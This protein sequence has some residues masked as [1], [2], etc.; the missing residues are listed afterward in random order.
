MHSTVGTWQAALSGFAG[1]LSGIHRRRECHAPAPAMETIV[2]NS[3]K[4]KTLQTELGWRW[5]FHRRRVLTGKQL[6]HQ[7]CYGT[8]TWRYNI[9]QL[10]LTRFGSDFPLRNLSFNSFTSLSDLRNTDT[11]TTR[12]I[13]HRTPR[14][15]ITLL[16]HSNYFTV[17]KNAKRFL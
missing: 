10:K 8:T 17:C 1:N 15:V 5:Y 11:S 14:P 2:L 16:Q 13:R 3:P 9:T 7:R 12:P 4:S 6:H